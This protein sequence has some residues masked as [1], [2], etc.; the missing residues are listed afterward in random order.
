MGSCP[1]AKDLQ[2]LVKLMSHYITSVLDTGISWHNSPVLYILLGQNDIF[3][4]L[5]HCTVFRWFIFNFIIRVISVVYFGV[6]GRGGHF[7]YEK[8]RWKRRVWLKKQCFL[9]R[10]LGNLWVHVKAFRAGVAHDSWK[11][12]FSN[13]F[14]TCFSKSIICETLL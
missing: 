5:N 14:T 4:F 12:N 8:L 2:F 10:V 7:S 1:F 11:K 3:Q 6:G 9:T 13:L